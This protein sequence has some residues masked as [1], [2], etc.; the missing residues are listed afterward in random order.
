MCFV[1]FH[2][3]FYQL[4]TLY[5]IYSF[6]VLIEFVILSLWCFRRKTKVLFF[7]ENISHP[8]LDGELLE[9]LI[10]DEKDKDNKTDK[11]ESIYKPL[12]R[13]LGLAKPEFW[14]LIG[15]M[16]GLFGN[17]ASQMIVPLLFSKL[18]SLVSPAGFCT[19]A[20]NKTSNGTCVLTPKEL[21]ELNEV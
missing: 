14:I 4:K 6:C 21:D 12:M 2:R 11:K 19:I 10:S 7:E 5:Y 8:S 1:H 16:I 3:N 15:G 20:N 13:L 17:T 18:T 9:S